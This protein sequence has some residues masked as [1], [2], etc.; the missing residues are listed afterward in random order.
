M[1]RRWNRGGLGW[2]PVLGWLAGAAAAWA[3]DSGA[4]W[5]EGK[6]E[7]GR[8]TRESVRWLGAEDLEA[9]LWRHEDAAG[10]AWFRYQGFQVG[11]LTPRAAPEGERAWGPGTE[12][13]PG[14]WGV[15]LAAGPFRGWAVQTPDTFDGGGQLA[16]RWGALTLAAGAD[17]T[18]SLDPDRSDT[19]PWVDA[20][21]VGARWDASSL[22]AALEARGTLPAAGEPGWSGRGRLRWAG[23]PAHGSARG[24]LRG[25]FGDPVPEGWEA[26]AS[27]GWRPWTATWAGEGPGDGVGRFEGRWAED[28]RSVWAAWEPT[29]EAGEAG[30]GWGFEVDGL[31]GA[32][33]ARVRWSPGWAGSVEGTLAQGTDRWAVAWSLG[34][35][36]G[37]EQTWT[38]AWVHDRFEAEAQWKTE[39]LSLGWLGPRS[40]VSLRLRWSFP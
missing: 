38:A 13:S 3:A 36:D 4:T 25:H 5:V 19:G 18:W 22:A 21:Q 20:G 17:R 40:A 16:A 15:D 27:L 34:T 7:N 32:V 14:H 33:R 26:S 35:G 10:A 29:V 31:R 1:K 39:G 8:L 28:E 23:G 24:A 9:R 6:V 30:G 37:V 2:L 11:P 12:L